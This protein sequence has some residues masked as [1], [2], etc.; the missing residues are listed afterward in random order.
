MTFYYLGAA[1]YDGNDNEDE[2][3]LA[4]TFEIKTWE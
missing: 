3:N 4:V 2:Q 1:S